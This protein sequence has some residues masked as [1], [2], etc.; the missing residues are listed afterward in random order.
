MVFGAIIVAAAVAFQSPAAAPVNQQQAV[1]R[2]LADQWIR[3]ARAVVGSDPMTVQTI[4]AATL[5]A[6]Q[7]VDIAPDH[8]PAWRF[9]LSVADLSEDPELQVRAVERLAQLDPDDEVIRLR[10]LNHEIDKLDTAEERVAMY[11]KLLDPKVRAEIGDAVASRLALDLAMLR[12]AQ[13]DTDG[14]SKWLAEA[15]AIDPS[16][17]KAAALA[18]GFFRANVDDPVAETELLISLA[19]ADP[20]DAMSLLTLG[21]LMLERGAYTGADRMYRQAL[22]V[23]VRTGQ[24]QVTDELIADGAIAQW[25]SGD[26][27]GALRTILEHQRYM[28]MVARAR[29][30][31]DNPEITP[32]ELAKINATLSPTLCSVRAMIQDT[33][34]GELASSAY[35]AAVESYDKAIAEA[36]SAEKADPATQ[37]RLL[38]EQAAIMLWL[39]GD[40]EEAS[41]RVAQA[42]TL[43]PLTQQATDRFDGWKAF[44][45]GDTEL[46]KQKLAPLADKD[47]VAAVGL[48]LSLIKE[49]E[50]KESARQLV[51]V[52]RTRPGTLLGVWAYTTLVD[53]LGQRFNVNKTSA[54][55][56]RLVAAIPSVF[57]RYVEDPSLLVSMRLIP[58]KVTYT[59]Y[60]PVNLEVEITNHS[61][62][63]IAI[64]RDG[65]LRP[66]MAL[67]TS[68]QVARV[69][70]PP[71]LP[72]FILD[73]DRKLRLMP[74]ERMR[75]K[76]DMRQTQLATVLDSNVLRG[77]TVIVR[78]LINF[79]VT[80]NGSLQPGVLGTELQTDRIRIDGV[81]VS[82]AWIEDSIA[83]VMA[84]DSVDDLT[85]IALLG[86]MVSAGVGE[87]ANAQDRQL[88]ADATTAFFDAFPKL[89]A[90]SQAWLL[91]VLPKTPS[92]DPIRAMARKS[93]DP[94]VQ[95]SYMLHQSS[96]DNDP[97]FDAVK[98]G[99]NPGLAELA[100][101]LLDVVRNA[102]Q[103]GFERTTGPASK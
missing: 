47:P 57:D 90:Y 97:V 75:V 31:Q 30:R 50:K 34:G 9:M 80:P 63:P 69:V 103:G 68:A 64:D 12:Q 48:A 100:E 41:S 23:A 5:L 81:R 24:P 42:N 101:I 70:L 93:N 61:T 58:S 40:V 17:R 89:D 99:D 20:T 8:L 85:R 77:A 91:C 37:A 36:A 29:T 44:R 13:G 94:A 51:N 79:M 92:M 15:S 65:P 53:M 55:L 3:I 62:V 98:R 26:A 33:M 2:M 1:S 18:A 45:A 49:G 21:Q 7:S 46:A 66:H 32:L 87:L 74:R 52:V 16:N 71:E 73:I 14:F 102:N 10:R 19:M 43:Q 72:P 76:I 86:P 27:G 83:A 60:E 38:L 67:V 6:E 95:L 88:M 28:D 59:P 11:R 78:G 56:D 54:E 25:A 82:R 4:R 35:Q 22:K 39:G 84:P 96:A